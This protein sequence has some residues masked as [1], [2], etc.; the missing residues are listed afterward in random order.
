[1]TIGEHS[2]Q[3][4]AHKPTSYQFAQPTEWQSVFNLINHP[5]LA[6]RRR[7]KPVVMH[8]VCERPLPLYIGEKVRWVVFRVLCHLGLRPKSTANFE[9]PPNMQTVRPFQ[10]FNPFPRRR[11]LLNG[12]EPLVPGKYHCGRCVD[13]GF[14]PESPCLQ[15]VRSFHPFCMSSLAYPAKNYGKAAGTRCEWCTD[16]LTTTFISRCGTFIFLRY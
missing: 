3:F 13:L 15:R 10:H 16:G 12:A 1:M 9:P 8:P 14:L 7:F 5:R 2:L 11:Q 6:W 4:R